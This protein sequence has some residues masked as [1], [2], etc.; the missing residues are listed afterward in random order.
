MASTTY[1]VTIFIHI[2]APGV[3]HFEEVQE[4]IKD[5]KTQISNP[6]AM[7]DNNILRVLYNLHLN[8]QNA[9]LHENLKN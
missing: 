3:I 2:N 6:V 9:Q 8:C 7:G 4:N 1:I 5:K